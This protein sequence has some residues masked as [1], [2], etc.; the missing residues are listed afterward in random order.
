MDADRIL[1]FAIDRAGAVNTYWNIYIAVASTVIG[2]V[3][4]LSG[5]DATVSAPAIKPVLAGAFIVFALSNLGAIKQL[6][7]L[8][9][10]LLAMLPGEMDNRAAIVESLKP[11]SAAVYTGFHLTL[12]VLVLAVIFHQDLPWP[13]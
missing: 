13:G 1:G 2:A 8:R 3:I 6:G 11:R 10:A 12:D 4:S 7:R 9:S 5:S